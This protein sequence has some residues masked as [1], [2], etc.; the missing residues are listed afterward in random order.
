GT[1][2]PI[3]QRQGEDRILVQV[4]G[5]SD[6][7]HVKNLLGKTAKMTFH[8]LAEDVDPEDAARGIAPPG[9]RL[10]DGDGD[11][12]RRYPVHGRVELS[13]DLLVDAHTTYDSQTG[14]P[15][16]AFRFNNAGARK[17][18]EITAANVGKPFAI[19]LDNKVITAPVIRSPIIGGS[20]IISGNFTTQSA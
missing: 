4:P 14:E 9:V 7:A 19:V 11:D 12:V 18:G 15:V 6:P 3:I 1:K 20:G 13:G 10:I 2:E 5:E 16:V 17:F 8:L